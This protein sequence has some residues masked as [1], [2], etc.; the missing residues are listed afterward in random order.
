M[1]VWLLTILGDESAL[2]NLESCAQVKGYL[3]NRG[4]KSCATM[5][6]TCNRQQLLPAGRTMELSQR[7]KAGMGIGIGTAVVTGLISSG[8]FP[9]FDVLPSFAWLLIAGLGG[10]VAGFV[11][12]PRALWG[13]AAGGLAGTGMVLSIWGYVAVRSSFGP[14]SILR[15]EIAIAALLGALPGLVMF[16]QRARRLNTRSK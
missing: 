11:A 12:S 3:K 8:F 7:E 14:D 5:L 16:S 13:S 1:S 9:D 10:T 2:K 4:C 15:I 6:R